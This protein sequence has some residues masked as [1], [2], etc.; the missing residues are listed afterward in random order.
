MRRILITETIRQLAKDYSLEMED[1]T[2]FQKRESPEERLFSLYKQLN[3]AST[4]IKV[5]KKKAS[6]GHPAVYSHYK[7][8]IFTR[9][10]DYVKVIY[11][12]YSGLNALLP[13]EWD[14]SITHKLDAILK[15]TEIH[16]I[17]VKIP[18]HSFRPF[19]ELIVEAMR[20]DA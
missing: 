17:V 20:Y 7:G 1:K 12:N 15:S 8:N 14:A 16:N 9:P 18:R 11:D 13:S 6:K 4:Q 5:L 19:Y 3:K 2:T 10:S